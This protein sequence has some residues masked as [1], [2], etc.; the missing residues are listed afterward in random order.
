ML[1]IRPVT[2][3]DL[4]R[5]LELSELTGFGLTTLPKD[6]DFLRR[7]IDKSLRSFA[8]N[9][10]QPAGE[11]YLF[12]MEDLATGQVVGTSGIVSKVGGYEP[13]YAYR[14]ETTVHASSVLHVHKEIRVL[15]LV[16]EHNGPAEICSLFLHPDYR[17]G[18]G[19]RLLSLSRFLFMAEHARRFD[20]LV[21]AE[22]RGVIDA[23]GGS[24]FWDAVGKHFFEIDFP[25]ADYLSLT[26][27]RFIAD[28]MPKYPVYIPLLPAAAQA[29]IGQVHPQTRPALRLLEEEGFQSS[30]MVDIFE[31]GPIVACPLAEVRTVR[32]SLRMPVTSVHQETPGDG[33][34]ATPAAPSELCIIATTTGEF[35]ACLGA[36]ERSGTGVRIPSDCAA[37]LGVDPGDFVRFAP[38]RAPVL[39][40]RDRVEEAAKEASD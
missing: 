18:G 23:Q 14:I 39:P 24:A 35:R 10:D 33:T 19:G 30:G 32:D 17:R 27:K 37:A 40:P 25:K 4:H 16:A 29:V 31:A 6:E 15:H 20:P 8:D 21:I 5:L 22:M 3:C 36:V 12:V 26:N 7:R 28:L 2:S 13:F 38:A 34:G 9:G 11:S 1:R